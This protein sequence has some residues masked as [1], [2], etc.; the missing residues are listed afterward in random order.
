MSQSDIPLARAVDDARALLDALL[1]SGWKDLHVLSGGTEIFIA[2][3]G[4]RPNPMREASVFVPVPAAEPPQEQLVTAPHVG[5]VVDV[6]ALGTMIAAG[7]PVATIR[8][9]EQEETITAQAAGAV[10]AIHA[11]IGALV[12]YKTPVLSLSGAA[13]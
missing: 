12:E 2:R 5:T 8:V 9:L 7:D 4:G 6:R 10:I 13:Q 11:A 3:E 1:S